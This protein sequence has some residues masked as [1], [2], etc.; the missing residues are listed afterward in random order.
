MRPVRAY[1][2]L[3]ANL[4]DAQAALTAALQALVALPQVRLHRTSAFYRTAPIEAHGP[5]YLNAVA[6]LDTTLAPLDL[7]A[8]LQGVENTFGRERPYRNAPRTLDLDLLLYGEERINS[9]TLTVPHPRMHER[10]FVLV[11]LAEIAPTGFAIPGHGE[12]PVLLAGVAWQ[13]IQR[14]ETP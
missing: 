7:L 8:Q 4:G 10:A 12:L 1:V 9:P 6:A 13:P 11:P 5:D 3:G 14:Q 2:G